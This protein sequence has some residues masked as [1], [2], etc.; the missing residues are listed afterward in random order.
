MSASDATRSWD[1]PRRTAPLDR[2]VAQLTGRDG[3]D[4][5]RRLVLLVDSQTEADEL[6]GTWTGQAIDVR[7]CDTLSAALL[8]IG[9]TSPDVV[10]IGAADGPIGV[11]DFLRTVRAEDSDTPVILGLD[12]TQRDLGVD[13][14]GA[15]VT[16][17]VR[18]PFRAD[19]LL[20][21]LSFT[22]PAGQPLPVRPLPIDLGG[23]L[24]VDGASPR[25]WLDG[26][27]TLLPPMEYLLLRFMAGRAGEI[28]SR[29]ELVDAVWGEGRSSNTLTVHL[30]RLRRRL[31][32]TTD[33]DWIRPVR[34]FGYQFLVPH[35]QP[36]REQTPPGAEA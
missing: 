12:D 8:L 27:E 23:R 30:A 4:P 36:A 17:I 35:T 6:T 11:I 7:A 28:L 24:R 19:E 31:K 3:G 29:T 10:V 1:D 20:R 18:R 13:A 33:G 21:I 2:Q 14:L 34:G 15:G 25:M 9:R 22:D 16:A 26:A 32:G 5:R